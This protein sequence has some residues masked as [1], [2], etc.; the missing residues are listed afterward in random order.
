MSKLSEKQLIIITAS[1][2]AAIVI[3]LGVYA[4]YVWNS[5]LTPLKKTREDL[6]GQLAA[7]KASQAEIPKLKARLEE[8]KKKQDEFKEKLPT[9]DEVKLEEFRKILVN[10]ATAAGVRITGLRPVVSAVPVGPT[11]GA[12][13]AKPFDEVSFNVDVSGNFATLGNFMYMIETHRRMIRV[14]TFELKPDASG[15]GATEPGKEL[16]KVM[17]AGLA[18]KLTT[19]QFK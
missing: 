15:G 3:G 6:Q 16:P 2:F 18:L 4:F 13:A 14:E 17:P 9:A 19:Y 7:E 11:G 8:L 1:S 5:D 10:Y 12:A